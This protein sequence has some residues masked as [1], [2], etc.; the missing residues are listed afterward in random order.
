MLNLNDPNCDNSISNWKN[1]DLRH[2]HH[3]QELK[4]SSIKSTASIKMKEI[5]LKLT[6]KETKKKRVS[7]V[8]TQILAIHAHVTCNKL[9]IFKCA[10]VN[11]IFNILLVQ[12]Q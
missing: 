2:H 8:H 7:V 1:L 5:Y 6:H 3:Q 11:I 9:I 12:L 4:Q 10:Q